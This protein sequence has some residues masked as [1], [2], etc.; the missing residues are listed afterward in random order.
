MDELRKN[1]SNEELNDERRDYCD[2][3]NDEEN[4][5]DYGYCEFDDD[6]DDDGLEPENYPLDDYDRYHDESEYEKYISIRE[7][8][9]YESDLLR[10]DISGSKEDIIAVI[11][12]C[13]DLYDRVGLNI[14]EIDPDTD[15]ELVVPSYIMR[16]LECE[17]VHVPSDNRK[18]LKKLK[19]A[20]IH[21]Y[22]ELTEALIRRRSLF[23]KEEYRD[24]SDFIESTLEL[25]SF[26]RIAKEYKFRIPSCHTDD[27][28]EAVLNWPLSAKSKSV[29]RLIDKYWLTEIMAFDIAPAKNARCTIE[30]LINHDIKT[31]GQLMKATMVKSFDDV[32]GECDPM[33]QE[34]ESKSSINGIL[35]IFSPEFIREVSYR[36][37]DDDNLEVL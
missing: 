24:L 25:D 31:Y 21:D 11:K 27:D 28:I 14:E 5:D 3:S 26:V 8:F 36:I 17:Y 19:R 33:Y 10:I 12:S 9:S 30:K 32:L 35:S 1:A 16:S 13:F 15:P 23:S 20:G 7:G 4:D 29:Y 37:H 2:L 6:E 22:M 18:L 34:D